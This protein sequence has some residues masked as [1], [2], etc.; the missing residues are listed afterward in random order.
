MRGHGD[1][2]RPDLHTT[3]RAG[4]IRGLH[5]LT[6][7]DP[8]LAA[9][10]PTVV[11][12]ELRRLGCDRGDIGL[13]LTRFPFQAH[14]T[15]AIGTDQRAVHRDL[16]I[17]LLRRSPVCLR[18]I[19]ASRL[20]SR[21][22]LA[23]GSACLWRMVQPDAFP[24]AVILRVLSEALSSHSEAPRSPCAELRSRSPT[25]PRAFPAHRPVAAS[26]PSRRLAPSLPARHQ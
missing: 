21:L 13:I 5:R 7:L 24:H 22:L 19:G 4:R 12:L 9:D 17:N 26:P 15:P 1:R 25:R 23:F 8:P 6:T 18:T 14:S 20:A 11:D 16:L 3:H 2:F 10:T